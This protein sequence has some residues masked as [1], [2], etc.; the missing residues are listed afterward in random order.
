[1]CLLK[2]KKL[3]YIP[4]MRHVAQILGGKFGGWG[5]GGKGEGG[6]WP[7]C[8]LKVILPFES[9]ILQVGVCAQW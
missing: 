5:E 2:A 4:H 6:S 1:M 8:T 3:L 7:M 9:H